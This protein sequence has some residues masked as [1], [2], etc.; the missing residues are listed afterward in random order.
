MP[1]PP[2][3]DGV[4]TGKTRWSDMDFGP[5]FTSTLGATLP[6]GNITHKGISIRLG[7]EKNAAVCFD[8]DLLRVSVGWT[9]DFV[10]IH[11]GREGLAEH[12]D[13]AGTPVFGTLAGPGWAK[14]GTE[15]FTDPRKDKLGPLPRDW[16]SIAGS[17][18]AM[19]VS[20]WLTALARQMCWK[21]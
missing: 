8:T 12:P 18:S 13:V 11:P 6:P 9:G 14:P 21:S 19:T 10:K 20:F 2:P 5:F 1:L 17:T 4:Q 3:D 7:K 15:D 16:G